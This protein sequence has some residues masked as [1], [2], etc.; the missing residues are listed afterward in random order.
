MYRRKWGF[1]MQEEEHHPRVS[2]VIL[3]VGLVVLILGLP[4]LA[5]GLIGYFWIVPEERDGV[6]EAAED[7]GVT[8]IPGLDLDSTAGFFVLNV[9][10]GCV[11]VAVGVIMIV[12][13]LFMMRKKRET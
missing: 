7:M 2:R 10:I 3:N 6:N 9:A 13:A 12:I 8:E 11:I 5:G 1:G 4:Y